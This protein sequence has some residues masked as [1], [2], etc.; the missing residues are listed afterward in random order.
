MEKEKKKEKGD[1]Q[2]IILVLNTYVINYSRGVPP[3][4][5]FMCN[6]NNMS[7]DN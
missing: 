4:G 5:E 7:N 2:Y 3:L 1:G 6:N